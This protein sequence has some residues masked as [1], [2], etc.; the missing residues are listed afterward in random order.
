MFVTAAP[1]FLCKPSWERYL[2]SC[3]CDHR[4]QQFHPLRDSRDAL[5]SP[6]KLTIP[7]TIQQTIPQKERRHALVVPREHGVWGDVAGSS[8]GSL[9]RV[10]E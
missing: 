5:G 9:L 2:E 6:T 3:K 8:S 10:V 7:R 1:E 4:R